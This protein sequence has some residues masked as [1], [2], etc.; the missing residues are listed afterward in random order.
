[1]L[2]APQAT[3]WECQ[4]QGVGFLT[5]R[6]HLKVLGPSYLKDEVRVHHLKAGWIPL[7]RCK[8]VGPPGGA[9]Q[10][11]DPGRERKTGCSGF[12]GLATSI[13]TWVWQFG[14][15]TVTGM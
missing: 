15:K 10:R 8:A 5:V 7:R 9:S 11:T 13:P 12:S 3:G 2:R 6:T 1:M 14:E 4:C